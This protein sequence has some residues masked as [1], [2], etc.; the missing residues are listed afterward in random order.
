MKENP[1]P[2]FAGPYADLAAYQWT[3]YHVGGQI[4]KSINT[5]SRLLINPSKDV[6]NPLSL[7]DN[8]KQQNISNGE[9]QIESVI[10]YDVLLSFPNI[11]PVCASHILKKYNSFESLVNVSFNDLMEIPGIG[12]SR[13]QT[14]YNNKALFMR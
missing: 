11:G 12:I 2:M 6:L 7:I 10:L 1:L 4:L 13:A 3:K 9:N 5:L 14:I 8:Y